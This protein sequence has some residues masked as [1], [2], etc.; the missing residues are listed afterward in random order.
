MDF[1]E[2]GYKMLV[3][4]IF[5]AGAALP[6]T[7]QPINVILSAVVLAFVRGALIAGANYFEPVQTTG[8]KSKGVR[9]CNW[10]TSVKKYV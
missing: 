9:C 7:I 5:G 6:Y 1:K 8:A 4:G 10:A 2:L 3:A